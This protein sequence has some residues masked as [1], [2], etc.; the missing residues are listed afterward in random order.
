MQI[1]LAKNALQPAEAANWRLAV[2]EAT[3]QDWTRF[4]NQWY[5]R[6]GHPI[7]NVAYEYN[8]AAQELRVTVKQTQHDSTRPYILPLKAMV[9]YGS[10][11]S[12][13]DWDIKTKATT[14][15]YPYCNGIKPVVIPDV[16]HVLPGEL[17]EVKTPEICLMQYQAAAKDDY[18]SRRR[19][20]AGAFRKYTDSA[21]VA[22]TDAALTDTIAGIRAYAL[23]LMGRASDTKLHQKWQGRVEMMAMNDGD[24]ETR[25]NAFELLGKWKVNSS[26]QEMLTALYDSSYMVGGAALMALSQI[27]NDTAYALSKAVLALD[28]HAELKRAAW[29][30]IGKHAAPED[31]NLYEQEARTTFGTKKF[32]LVTSLFNYLQKVKDEAAF[33]RGT[34]VMTDMILTEDMKGY[35]MGLSVYLVQLT[36][37]YRQ[38]NDKD[39]QSR[40]DLLQQKQQQ[41]LDAEKDEEN[42]KSLSDMIK[43]IQH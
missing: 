3:G 29:A 40:L 26:K 27:D 43:G 6:A 8:D 21:A 20:L 4:F 17:E 22:L 24:P 18:I 42:K 23:E 11:S 36:G 5:S 14:F 13:A 41:M 10:Q 25:S 28:P 32:S 39:M 34:E 2:E 37:Y 38:K 16:Q 31:I 35:R 19:A 1:Y 33:K 12:I 15:S 30:I 9:A 7:L